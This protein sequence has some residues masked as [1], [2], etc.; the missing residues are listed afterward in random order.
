MLDVKDNLKLIVSTLFLAE[1][2]EM[3]VD[4]AKEVTSG[5]ANED[6][7][8]GGRAIIKTLDLLIDLK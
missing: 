2:N 4:Q 3:S 1:M 6:G 7:F 5:P 8:N